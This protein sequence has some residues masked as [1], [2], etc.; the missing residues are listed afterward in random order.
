MSDDTTNLE[1]LFSTDD[2][3]A[4]PTAA[5]LAAAMRR[6]RAAGTLATV[7][8]GPFAAAGRELSGEASDQE[9]ELLAAAHQRAQMLPGLQRAQ[10]A[11]AALQHPATAR[12][13]TGAMAK[14]MPGV[15]VSDAPPQVLEQLLPTAE[16]AYGVDVNAQMRRDVAEQNRLARQA[17][18]E[19]AG[20]GHGTVSDGGAAAI[21]AAIV[22]GEQPPTVHARIEGPVRAALAQNHPGFNLTS[23]QSDWN[24]TQRHLATLNGP[25]QT[26]LRQAV[27]A[28]SDQLSNVEALYDQ[29]KQV[30]TA[31]GIRAFNRAALGSAKQMPG[32]A[33]AVAQAL[34][35]QISL[36]TGELGNVL[37]GGNS[38]TDH[39]L[40][41][42]GTM[43]QGDWNEET[44]TKA[45]GQLR[46]D[47]QIRRN[48]MLNST[49]AGLSTSPAAQPAGGTPASPAAAGGAAPRQ[50]SSKAERD[51]LPPGTPYTRPGDPTV[52][53]KR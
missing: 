20:A 29:W 36:L 48:S 5:A 15:D 25:Q 51:A 28:T 8:G 22:N 1:D 35:G 40:K 38:P 19:H 9:R 2:A 24:A 12:V 7:L 14:L 13:L 42:A 37:M 17:V 31:S 4:I 33:G 52:Y 26:R 39:G 49:P 46:R 53:V 30:G 34:E 47:L 3:T 43:L 45:I 32:Q 41:L 16:K 10:D 44:F 6:R 27:D 23:A 50:V 18:A 21:A 11:R